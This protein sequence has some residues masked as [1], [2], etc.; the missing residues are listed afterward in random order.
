MHAPD[1]HAAAWSPLFDLHSK[2]ALQAIEHSCWGHLQSAAAG[3]ETGWRLP[4]LGTTSAR[5]CVQRTVVLRGVSQSEQTL[6]FHTDVRSAK[7]QQLKSDPRVSLA[8]YDATRQIQLLIQGT[9]RIHTEGD[10]FERLWQ[11][12]TE[13]SLKTYLAP[14]PPGAQC[15][16]PDPNLPDFAVGRIPVRAETEAGRV[17]FAVITVVADSAEWLRLSIRGNTRARFRYRDQRF[18]SAEWLTP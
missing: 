9:A 17:N 8:F 14:R 16:H 13:S 11:N 15:L 4:V 12:A 1:E 7:I 18:E 5:G 10:C 6:M 2:D 3:I